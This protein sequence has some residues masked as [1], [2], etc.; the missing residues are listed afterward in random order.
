M[1][2]GQGDATEEF[3]ALI[4]LART[5][6][7]DLGP[8]LNAM[9]NEGL[10]RPLGVEEAER[11]LTKIVETLRESARARGD[12]ATLA[13]LSNG[14]AELVK[15]A[16]DA[17]DRVRLWVPK[18]AA[19]MAKKQTVFLIPNHNGVV[20]GPVVPR[21]VFH[22][23][24]IDMV[25]GYIMTRDIK[26][27]GNNER[28]EIHVGQFKSKY[29]RSPTA[30]ELFQIMLGEMPLEGVEARDEFEV[31]KLARS[32]A[33]NGVRK[34]PIL[35]IDGTLLDGN[36]RVAACTLI[37]NDTEEFTPDEKKRAEYL[38]VWQ[39]T[40]GATDD[41]RDKVIVSL[42][43]ES[44]YKKEWPEYIKA[45]KILDEWEYM[46]GL[47][48]QKPGPKR[49]AE[50]KREL[51]RKYA[52]GPD[53]SVVSRYLKMVRW[54]NDFEDHHINTRSRDSFQIKH[55][56]NKYFQYF[57]EIAKGESQGGVAWSL[58][59]D[60]ELKRTVFD[61][62]FDG[63]IDN[64]TQ[65][66]ALKYIY[67]SDEA[68]DA[69]AKAHLEPDVDRAQEHVDAAI[70]IAN[71]RRAEARSMG[72]NLRIETF[73]KWIEEVPPRTLRDEVK[74]G[75]LKRLL[76]AFKLVQSIVEQSLAAKPEANA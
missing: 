43:F 25:G 33:A 30:Q 60:D 36:R 61:L 66:R 27:W 73:T 40:P 16:I 20:A 54:S 48:P 19:G 4:E 15:A 69:L 1:S 32:I 37:L 49:Q 8:D 9:L 65:I 38:F 53:T 68:R 45:R 11:L 76:A 52:L 12:G 57:D 34:P 42:N 46:L 47:E 13:S 64:Y 59:Q 62:L 44:D 58:N 39:L 75:N 51:S 26:L 70:T 35:D 24:E 23:M 28:L 41:D 56:A 31:L 2:N 18:P 10:T 72:A 29:G 5:I 63:K 50:M 14:A 67:Q 7:S 55:A 21:P 22:E 3:R 6:T 71:T 74:P 17:R